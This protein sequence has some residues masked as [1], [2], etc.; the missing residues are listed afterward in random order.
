MIPRPFSRVRIGYHPP[1]SVGPGDT[2][3]AAAMESAAL[4]LNQIEERIAWPDGAAM[5]I[6]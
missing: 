4:A 5:A 6:A 1:M 2:G 3:L